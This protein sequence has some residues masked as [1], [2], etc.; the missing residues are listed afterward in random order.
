MA[1]DIISYGNV[2]ENAGPLKTLLDSVNNNNNSHMLEVQPG[3]Y[4][5][6]SLF[7][8]PI[9]NSEMEGYDMANDQNN[10]PVQSQPV[11]TG[12]AGQGV[13]M[14]QFEKDLNIAIQNSLVE[15]QRKKEEESKKHEGENNA[16]KDVIPNIQKGEDE[17]IVEENEEEEL[18]KARLLSLKVHEENVK[19]KSEN[20][21]KE[22]DQFLNNEDFI[23][24]V[25]K[26]INCGE[27]DDN[28]VKDV[29]KKLKKDEEM[30]KNDH[31][32]NENTPNEEKEKEG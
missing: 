17:T 2:D 16:P 15:D 13:G 12:V 30:N 20:D 23:K 19:M 28:L 7:S 32:P 14:S 22:K 11:S 21:E 31:T 25:L 9:I 29:M 18:E 27:S 10:I 3:F 26:E 24:D 6:D 1:I 4:L 5:V 8:S